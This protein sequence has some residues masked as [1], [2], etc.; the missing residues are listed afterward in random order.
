MMTAPLSHVAPQFSH[1]LRLLNEV[2]PKFSTGK[3]P[4]ST[5]EAC[6][7]CSATALG[8]SRGAE[9]LV[10]IVC[11]CACDDGEDYE[12]D[13]QDQKEIHLLLAVLVHLG[14][15]GVIPCSVYEPGVERRRVFPVAYRDR[16]HVSLV[17]VPLGPPVV[18]GSMLRASGD[19]SS[20]LPGEH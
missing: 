3:F 20:T 15:G 6:S 5:M 19:V 2:T 8:R 4:A 9:T 1:L 7:A 12:A 16:V 17:I 13:D 14:E 11:S 18:A 10:S